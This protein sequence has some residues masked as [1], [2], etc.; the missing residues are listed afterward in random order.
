MKKILVVFTGGT[1]CSIKD[2][3]GKNQSDAK[4]VKSVLIDDYLSSNSPFKNAVKFSAEFLTPDILSENMTVN[5][6]TSIL[7]ILKKKSVWK[8]FDGVIILHGT[9]TLAYTTAILSI[10]L[11]GA[12]I[13]IIT[14]SAN[15]P[16]LI[17]GK[18]NL[19][20]NGYANF[21]SSVELILNGI[22]PNVYSVYRNDDNKTYIHYGANLVQCQNYDNNFYSFGATVLDDKNA[23]F[24]GKEFE[25]D[26][27]Y[28]K[29]INK[30]KDGVLLISPYTGLDYLKI[31]LKG[32]RAIVHKTYHAETVCV[33]IKD[34]DQKYGKYSILSL[35][36]RAKEK[37][38]PVFLTPCD[39]NSYAYQST[40]FAIDRGATP[41]FGATSEVIYA[42]TLI[43]VSLKL[44]GDN[45]IEFVKN[46]VNHEF[47]R[48]K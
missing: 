31:S 20:T 16:L 8:N 4:G 38:V 39:Q 46:S 2:F 30:L 32:V 37:N 23:I 14:V 25:T 6:L 1:I 40:S 7:K 24:D 12:P 21:R 48:K 42:K 15:Y 13:P 34:K 45:L 43:G 35:L 9:D 17:D 22:K 5:T 18:K 27:F 41:I 29:D 11:A 33:E 47:A 19:D 36:D 3:D 28:I 10:A 44:R 26:S